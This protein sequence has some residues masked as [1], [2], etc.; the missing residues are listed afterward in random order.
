[1]MVTVPPFDNADVRNALK[2]AINREDIIK[3]VF[4]GI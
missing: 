1:M 4:N 2:Y 3:L